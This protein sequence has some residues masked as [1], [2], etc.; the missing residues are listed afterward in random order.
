MHI[1]LQLLFRQSLTQYIIIYGTESRTL[2]AMMNSGC[3]NSWHSLNSMN[4]QNCFNAKGDINAAPINH[5]VRIH[6]L[7]D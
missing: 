5:I 7:Q 2:R 4:V 1:L 3:D 6:I